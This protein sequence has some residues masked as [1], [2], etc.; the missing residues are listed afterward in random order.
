LVEA[1]DGDGARG[2]VGE[3]VVVAVDVIVEAVDEDEFG[4]W[5]TFRLDGRRVRLAR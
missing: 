5:R 1:V 4:L 2:Q 3:E